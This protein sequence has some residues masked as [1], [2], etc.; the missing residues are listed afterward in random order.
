MQTE[1]LRRAIERAGSVSALARA[2]GVRPQAVSQWKS[3]PINRVLLIEE[4]LGIPRH[5]LRPDI[6]LPPAIDVRPEHIV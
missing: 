1:E 5:Q 6:C 2:A 3:V 4:K